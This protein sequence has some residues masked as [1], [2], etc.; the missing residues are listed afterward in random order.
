MKHISYSFFIISLL[1]V[2][3][4]FGCSTEEEGLL[5]S[6]N[7]QTPESEIQEVEK[8]SFNNY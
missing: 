3:F 8:I 1:T 6:P 4:V 5:D 2:V 7:V